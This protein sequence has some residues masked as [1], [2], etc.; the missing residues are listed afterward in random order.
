M[1]VRACTP[2]MGIPRLVGLPARTPLFLRT[3]SV[4]MVTVCPAP[5]PASGSQGAGD[6][7]L[8]IEGT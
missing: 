1:S 3:G 6:V 2:H 5:C 7:G 4:T 8:Y